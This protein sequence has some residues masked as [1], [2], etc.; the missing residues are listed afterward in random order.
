LGELGHPVSLSCKQKGLGWIF[1]L[2]ALGRFVRR[3]AASRTDHVHLSLREK[4]IGEMGAGQIVWVKRCLYDNV[5]ADE[6]TGDAGQFGGELLALR[7]KE[8]MSR[9]D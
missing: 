5:T 4:L 1:L 9:G 2:L 7:R 3:S 6:I 8:L